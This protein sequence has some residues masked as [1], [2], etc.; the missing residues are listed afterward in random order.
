MGR[1]MLIED[2]KILVLS[3][4]EEEETIENKSPTITK[5]DIQES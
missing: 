4:R 5:V 1:T 3:D 2:V